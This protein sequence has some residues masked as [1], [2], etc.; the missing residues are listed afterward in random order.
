MRPVSGGG[1]NWLLEWSRVVGS[2]SVEGMRLHLQVHLPRRGDDGRGVG[3]RTGEGGRVGERI[4]LTVAA[5]ER[6]GPMGG[7]SGTCTPAPRHNAQ[8]VA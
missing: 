6:T 4:D 5:V 8:N 7:N 1:V 2:G 3:G